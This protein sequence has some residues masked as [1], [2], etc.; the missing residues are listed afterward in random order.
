VTTLAVLVP[1][2]DHVYPG[3]PEEPGRLSLLRTDPAGVDWLAP[4]PALPEEIAR[5]H[6]KELVKG[7]RLV[8]ERE[9]GI[10]DYAPTYV[11]STSYDDSLLAAGA[12]LDVTRKVMDGEAANGFAIVRP[13]GHHAEPQ[14]SMGF[15]IFNNIAVAAQDA[16]E[17]GAERVLIVDYDAHHGN[18]TQAYAWKNERAAYL[19]THQENI[20]PGSGAIQEAPHARGRII[21]VPLPTR[22]GDGAFALITGRLI[23]PLVQKFQPSLILVS[24]GFD[25]HWDD[26]LTS[27]GL[28]TSGF[29]AISRRLVELAGE[30]CKGRIVFVLEGGYNPVNIAN[31]SD[32]VFAA[33][34][35]TMPGD[36]LRRSPHREPEFESRVEAVRKFH[37]F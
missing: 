7:I 30:W 29:H 34:T 11:T 36:D 8:C 37:D 9:P 26:P 5:V 28:T 31:G 1:S 3:H 24:A 21:N 16:L 4:K 19:S 10:I 33:L 2:T 15:C 20:Y 27:L 18:G 14:R 22:S 13:P 23:V 25:S 35:N 12:T 6:A 17:R 32:A